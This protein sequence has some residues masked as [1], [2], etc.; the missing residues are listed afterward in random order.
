MAGRLVGDT[1]GAI[2][3]CGNHQQNMS[4]FYTF[5][6]ERPDRQGAVVCLSW[7]PVRCSDHRINLVWGSSRHTLRGLTRWQ[8][9][10]I[11]VYPGN[12]FNCRTTK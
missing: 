11:T 4:S 7:T 2:R 10:G 5:Q 9:E 1:V 6:P 12:A 8:Y 3:G